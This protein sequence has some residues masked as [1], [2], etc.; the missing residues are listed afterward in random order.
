MSAP[1]PSC[2]GSGRKKL[3]VVDVTGCRKRP[4]LRA[5]FGLDENGE[6]PKTT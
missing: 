5:Y 3:P 4:F 2:S 6:I 1:C